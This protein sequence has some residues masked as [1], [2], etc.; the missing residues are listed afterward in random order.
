M[1]KNGTRNGNIPVPYFIINIFLEKISL[2]TAL[3]P[4]EPQGIIHILAGGA[5]IVGVALPLPEGQVA[6]GL[7]VS[8]GKDLRIRPHIHD[9][10]LEAGVGKVIRAGGSEDEKVLWAVAG[11]SDDLLHIGP[12]ADGS[13]AGGGEVAEVVQAILKGVPCVHAPHG[14]AA[15]SA[16]VTGGG[17]PFQIR[18]LGKGAVFALG[19]GNQVVYQLIVEIIHQPEGQGI[20]AA[21]RFTGV[22]IGG[23]NNNKRLDQPVLDGVVH[24]MLELMGAFESPEKFV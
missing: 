9:A 12:V 5:A 20:A 1:K 18:C 21:I 24:D 10:P 11:R 22:V 23:Q 14:E 8:E 16:V 7:A 6:L 4:E 3:I 15:E 13:A 17:D 19:G 2:L